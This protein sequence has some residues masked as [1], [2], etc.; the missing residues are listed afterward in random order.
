M[1]ALPFI[2]RLHCP[3]CRSKR[4]EIGETTECGTFWKTDDDGRFNLEDGIL[5]PGETTRIDVEC[6]SCGHRWR[7]KKAVN[8]YSVA[9]RVSTS[10]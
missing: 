1:D 3:K 7:A 8:I 2:S 6:R 9:V 10:K 5:E 4:L